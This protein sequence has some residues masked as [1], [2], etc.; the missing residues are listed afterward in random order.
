[1]HKLTRVAL[2]VAG[3]LMVGQQASAQV[4]SSALR[5][6]LVDAD[7]NPLAGVTVELV[8]TPT[9]SK[10]VLTTTANGIFQSKGLTVGGPYLVKLQDGSKYK[11]E[12]IEDLYLQLGK[13]A[14]IE[15]VAGKPASQQVEVIAVKASALSLGAY[16]K[17][18]S[19]EFTE[20]DVRSTPA[21]SRDFKSLL[22]RESKIV[23]DPTADGG[24]ALSIAGGSVRGN[25]I[26]VDGV[27]QNDDFGL[28]KNGYPGRRA[29][30]SLD[31]IEQVSVNIAP[32][33]VTYGDFL[34]GNVNIVTKSG[35]NEFS[36]SLSYY[37]ADDSMIGDES[38]GDT[39]SIGDFEEDTYGFTLGG[40]IIED[41]LFFFA[42]YE[43]FKS[44]A[45]YQFKLDNLNG[46]VEANERIGVTQ[47][48]YDAI[49]TIARD[50]WGYDIGRY[51][52]PKKEDNDNLLLKLDWY[53]NDDHRMSL[54]YQDNEGNTVRD[55]WAETFPLAQTATAESNRYNMIETL[56][57]LSFQWF[58]DW[59]DDFSTE[60]KISSKEVETKQVPLM[61]A[62]F[63]QMQIATPNGG[64]LFI[65]PDQ[66][67]HA[68]ELGNDRVTFSARGDYYLDDE[69]KLTFGWDHEVQDVY[70]L[71]V[72][73]ALGMSSF[74]SID[75]FA[76]R[77]GFHV[78]Q[79]ALDGNPRSAVD[80][81]QF[82]IDTFYIQDEYN[83]NDD[84][85]FIYGIRYEK[86]SN[87]DKP[88]L[89][90]EFVTRHGYSNQSNFDGLDLLSPRFG[91]TYNYSDDTV[92]RGGLGLFGGG[93]PKVWLS[94]SYGNDGK[95]KVFAVCGGDCFDGR[96]TP[97]SV[98]EVLAQGTSGNTNSVHPDFEIPSVWKM[99]L[100]LESRL[101]LGP[102]GEDWLVNADVIFSDVKHAAKYRE[103]N[104]EAVAI[105]P[106][107]RPIYSVP[108]V[109]DLSLENT[110]KG[111]GVVLS[112]GA[113]NTFYTDHGTYSVDFGYTYQ[114]LTEVNPGNAF[115]A[116][117]GY[118]M[119]ANWD[120]QNDVEF[121]SEYE[122][123]H[124]LTGGLTWSNEVFGDN[125]TTVSILYTGR[126]GRHYSHTM[127]TVPGTFGGLV[128]FASWEAYGS[129]SLYIPTSPND[130]LVTYAPGFDTDAFFAYINSTECLSSAAGTISRRHNCT[131][132]WINRF[133]VRIA[134]QVMITD[135]QEIELTLDIEN[136]G[137][138]LNDNWG[139]VH[140]YVQPFN[141]PIVDV[142][143]TADGSQYIYDNFNAPTQTIKQV[144]SVWKI[145][146]GVT[147]R[148]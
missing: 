148:F 102:M 1:M 85:T 51:D 7:G 141:A 88:V 11:A 15:L 75:D 46:V 132:D 13:T 95:R 65:G 134:Q 68:N 37:R 48:D 19:A 147:Y 12:S 21:I 103:L 115:V 86:Y 124:T 43:K 34:G 84:L 94:N 138:M 120:F 146:L 60:V 33:D 101:D 104:M 10:K 17:G 135:E 136:F 93:G 57:A 110:D 118:S 6:Q 55:Y 67:R 5:G 25:S 131:S 130:P 105:A 20:D 62:N 44:T 76:N 8:H 133:D 111:G 63:A 129:Q 59:N 3:A 83:Y 54:T 47:A 24:P 9:G 139:R 137:N 106:D 114:D 30:I 42:S 145:Q 45:P 56:E 122:V 2:F 127:N 78:F 53:V 38:E 69:H 16:K 74:G 97:P 64:Q 4:T 100:G 73:G 14:N 112:F 72:F 50:V 22:K 125:T 39:L 41:E 71:F 117:E 143:L 126:E 29:P 87:D 23:V 32:F 18:P 121:N 80:E 40:P 66:F 140:G 98:L 108:G 99:N 142:A 58:A 89:N 128:G 26:T 109:F 31:A 70:N 116:F 92:I 144:A 90:P 119:P 96:N 82:T 49:A 36:G 113:R 77:A 79:N 107:G 52:A 27:K 61:G 91:F 123:R 35:T 81:F 28:N